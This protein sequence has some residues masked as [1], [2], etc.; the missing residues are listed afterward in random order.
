MRFN[1][2]FDG[3]ATERFINDVLFEGQLNLKKVGE[4]I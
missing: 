2:H 1:E 4:T 3:K